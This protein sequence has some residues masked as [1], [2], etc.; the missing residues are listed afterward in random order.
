MVKP[1]CRR[2]Q[3]DPTYLYCDVWAISLTIH[4]KISKL[5]EWLYFVMRD[6]L[7]HYTTLGHE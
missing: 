1:S 3:F 5:F 4:V 7:L 2:F 6:V